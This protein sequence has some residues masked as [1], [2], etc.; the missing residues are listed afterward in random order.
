M[1]ESVVVCTPEKG[2]VKNYAQKRHNKSASKQSTIQREYKKKSGLSS[3]KL[4]VKTMCPVKRTRQ[5]RAPKAITVSQ[6]WFP[7]LDESTTSPTGNASLSPPNK[8]KTK[9]SKKPVKL[10]EISEPVN[11]SNQHLEQIKRKRYIL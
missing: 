3:G 4:I 6:T 9:N 11:R 8:Q 5:K 2:T 1:R 10:P 7:S